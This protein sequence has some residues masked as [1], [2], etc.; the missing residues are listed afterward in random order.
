MSEIKNFTERESIQ[1]EYEELTEV[2][3]KAWLRG[4]IKTKTHKNLEYYIEELFTM[5][6]TFDKKILGEKRPQKNNKK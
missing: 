4:I 3:L 6:E 1:K 2:L 5:L